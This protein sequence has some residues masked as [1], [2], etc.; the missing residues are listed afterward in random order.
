LK[1]INGHGNN[2]GVLDVVVRSAGDDFKVFPG[3]T[4]I[5][6]CWEKEY[7][8]KNRK[9]NPGGIGHAC[10]VETSVMLHLTDDQNLVDM[11]VADDTDIMKSDLKNCPVDFGATRKKD[12]T[13]PHGILKTALKAVQGIPLM[14]QKNLAKQFIR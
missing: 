2:P 6:D 5:F 8:I 9:S 7:I 14:Q 11:S 10:E 3:V 12:Y 1:N 13:S 4:N